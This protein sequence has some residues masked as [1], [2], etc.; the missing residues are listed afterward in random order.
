MALAFFYS[1]VKKIKFSFINLVSISR[2]SSSPSNPVYTRC[3]D[4]FPLCFSLSSHQHSYIGFDFISPTKVMTQWSRLFEVSGCFVV[5]SHTLWP[6]HG[7]HSVTNI[8]DG[9][10]R[11]T[12][13]THTHPSVRGEWEGPP[14]HLVNLTPPDQGYR[15][16]RVQ[17]IKKFITQLYVEFLILTF[18]D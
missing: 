14:I 13:Y 11:V 15:T 8:D 7:W 6:G 12:F 2:C 10:L 9:P 16:T 5:F 1:A 17:W 18:D 3:V 4:S